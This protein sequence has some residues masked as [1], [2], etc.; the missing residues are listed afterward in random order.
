MSGERLSIVAGQSIKGGLTAKQEGFAQGVARGLTLS[1][2]YRMAY[3][4]E[5]MKDATIWTEASSLVDN[6][7][8]AT[9]VSSLQKAQEEK[10]LHDHAR[11]KRLVL[12]RL[13][14]EAINA[15]SDSARIRALELLGKSIAMFTDRVE[16]D[17][18]SRTASEI[19]KELM[20]RLDEFNGG[21][22]KASG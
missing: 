11:L 12:E 9:R 20:K 4:A 13:H 14:G 1:D 6:P 5:K 10:T 17:D 19:E 22:A 8:V 7:K 18:Q 21:T 16:Q 2:A 15:E 3:D